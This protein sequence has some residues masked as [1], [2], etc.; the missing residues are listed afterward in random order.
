MFNLFWALFC[1]SLKLECKSHY[2]L[3]YLLTTTAAT[4][5]YCVLGA[6]LCTP[7]RVLLGNAR[8]EILSPDIYRRQ[9]VGSLKLS[10]FQVTQLR[11]HAKVCATISV[12]R[13]PF[14]TMHHS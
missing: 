13:L 4:P 5:A 1:S 2:Y 9:N 6:V 10:H 14:P 7:Y 11:L 8:R 12:H 3:P